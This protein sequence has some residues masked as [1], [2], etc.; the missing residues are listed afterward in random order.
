MAVFSLPILIPFRWDAHHASISARREIDDGPQRARSRR[1]PP[2]AWRRRRAARGRGR[3][4]DGAGRCGGSAWSWTA[5]STPLPSSLAGLPA[6]R[7]GR[8]SKPA[9]SCRGRVG[10]AP[11]RSTEAAAAELLCPRETRTPA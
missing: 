9:S 2:R 3:R 4:A 10:R 1:R 6:L 7:T 8:R 11:M 5:P